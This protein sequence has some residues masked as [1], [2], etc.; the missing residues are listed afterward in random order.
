MVIF[1]KNPNGLKLDKFI[2]NCVIPH[3]RIACYKRLD[4][5]LC[6]KWSQ[7]FKTVDLGWNKSIDHKKV[8]TPSAYDIILAG[9]HNITYSKQGV[10]Y[11]IYINNNEIIPKGSAKLYDICHLINY[12]NLSVSPYPIFSDSFKEVDLR[13][14][15][16]YDSFEEDSY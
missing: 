2:K 3:V 15:E 1:I 6:D 8:I 5:R 16:L 12:G 14:N 10:D 13:I 7:Y 9:I 4:K 11:R